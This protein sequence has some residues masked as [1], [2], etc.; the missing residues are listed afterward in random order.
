MNLFS[1]TWFFE[2]VW[3]PP[4]TPSQVILVVAIAVLL[5]QQSWFISIKNLSVFILSLIIGFIIN[6]FYTPTWSVELMLLIFALTISLLV[7]LRLKLIAAIL[8]LLLISSGIALGL[9]SRP[10]MIPGFGNSIAVNWLLG[11]TASM[12][13]L[14]IA[15]NLPTYFLRNLINGVV[16]RVIGSWIATSALFVLV[17]AV[18]KP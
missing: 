12:S 5:A 14:F 1:T 13:A 7:T 8:F 10:I 15:A 11:A 6:H 17:L 18:A 16:L 2:G 3:H 9:D 4:Q